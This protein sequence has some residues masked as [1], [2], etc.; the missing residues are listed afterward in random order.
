MAY[1]VRFTSYP[2]ADGWLLVVLVGFILACMNYSSNALNQ[3]MDRDIDALQPHKKNRPIPSGRISSQEATGLVVILLLITLSLG[4]SVF[5]FWFGLLLSTIGV[6]VWLYNTPPLRLRMRLIWSNFSMSVPRGAL[7]IIVAYSAFA[8]PLDSRILVPALA[9]G[10]YVF[11]CNTFKDY[12]DYEA[13]K[14]MGVRNFCTVYGKEKA[15]QIV[16]PFLYIPFL[17]FFL[18]GNNLTLLCLPLSSIMTVILRHNPGLKAQGIL[19]WKLFY[20][21]FGLMMMLYAV[22]FLS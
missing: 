11:G 17:I 22:P 4:Y 1:R 9:F 6:F 10:I 3:I 15:S 8:D 19:I 12:E 5:G 7:G 14:K 20:L 21:Q 18:S 13:D 16:L 2:D